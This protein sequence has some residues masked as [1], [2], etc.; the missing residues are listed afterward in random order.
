[1]EMPSWAINVRDPEAHRVFQALADP[2]WDFRTEEGISAETHL[3]VEQV[4]EILMRHADLIRK[5]FVPGRNG[6]ALYT[7]RDHPITARERVAE[8]FTFLSRA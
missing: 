4:R 2:G 3:P 5:S 1:M 7:L 8:A 6:R